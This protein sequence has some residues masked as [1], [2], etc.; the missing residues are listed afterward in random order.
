V[1]N[2]LNN[3]HTPVAIEQS[4]ISLGQRIRAQ[5]MAAQWT[6]EQTAQRLFCSPNTYSALEAG[7]PTVSL[8][9]LV[10]ALWLFGCSDGLDE[11]CPLP[12]TDVSRRRV[13]RKQAPSNVI[14]DDERDF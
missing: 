8:G 11:L 14:E 10:N 5:R 6:I 9:L 12:A 7:K 1:Q 4:L 2:L 13:R 3:S